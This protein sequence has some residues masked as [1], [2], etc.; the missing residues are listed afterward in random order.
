MK[1]KISRAEVLALAALLAN[2]NLK[3][4]CEVEAESVE[5]VTDADVTPEATETAPVE[6]TEEVA[7]ATET[8][9]PE[10]EVAAPEAT[11]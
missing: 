11:V 5:E 10:T 8:V 6:T 7:P 1:V 2:D 3:E 4:F 9:A